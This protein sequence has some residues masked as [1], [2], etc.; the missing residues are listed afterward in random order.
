M[1]SLFSA[2]VAIVIFAFAP[3]NAEAATTYYL[4]GTN[5]Q[6]SSYYYIE[7]SIGLMVSSGLVTGD[8][9]QSKSIIPN[10]LLDRGPDGLGLAQWPVS[11]QNK[12][13][14]SGNNAIFFQFDKIVSLVNMEFANFTSGD[15]FSFF[16]ETG[17][18]GE[19][20]LYTTT[21]EGDPYSFHQKWVGVLFGTGGW[22]PNDG[23]RVLSISIE[24][25][26]VIPLPIAL[27]LYG[28]GLAV[29]GYIGWRKRRKL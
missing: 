20:S 11:E 2:V 7:S 14:I 24:S 15:E 13:S 25:A 26:S 6:S 19:F 18:G 27:P 16:F 4:G 1:K 10:G 28:T 17:D 5:D 21:V 8:S 12:N 23:T 9:D 3:M 29:L 22:E